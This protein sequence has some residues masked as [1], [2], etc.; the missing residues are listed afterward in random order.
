MIDVERRYDAKAS[1]IQIKLQ[2]P[3]PLPHESYLPHN[4]KCLPYVH[5]GPQI[6][7]HIYDVIDFSKLKSSIAYSCKYGK[8]GIV[9]VRLNF[10]NNNK[11]Y[12][13]MYAAGTF[14]DL[15]HRE[16]NVIQKL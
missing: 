12:I 13:L 8:I 6:V 3:R 5:A 9:L 1:R 16:S 14:S 11:K 15:A 10:C 4:A 2:P 7:C